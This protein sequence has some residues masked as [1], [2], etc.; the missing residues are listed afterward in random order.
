MDLKVFYQKI[1]RVRETISAAHVVTVSLETQDG[2]REGVLTEVT[3]EVAARLIVE[4]RARLAAESEAADFMAR[5][6]EALREA[7]EREAQQR[8][9]LTVL[10]ERDMQLLRSQA[11]RSKT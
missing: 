2:G 1:R 5:R 10:S 8:V 7:E 4:G 6:M 11:N 9:Q 3:R